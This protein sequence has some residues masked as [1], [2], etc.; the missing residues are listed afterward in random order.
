MAGDRRALVSVGL[1]VLLVSS[2]C[3][4][5]EGPVT[6]EANQSTVA[7]EARQDTGYEEVRVEDQTVVRSFGAA[8]VSQEVRVV[9]K[10][11]EYKRQVDLAVLTGELA[12]FSVFTSPS[13]EVAGQQFNPVSD[14]TNAELA[15]L[16]QEEYG[17]VSDVSLEGNRTVELVGRQATVSRFTAR[18]ETVA[19]QSVDVYLHIGQAAHENDYVVVIAVYPRQLDEQ[20][21]V[22]RLIGGVRHQTGS[23]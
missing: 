13:V 5:L 1:A 21:A 6:F 12:R 2:G 4:F 7:E 8:N 17:T 9:N 20:A 3:S 23:G 15:E 18:A 22:D 16:V 14:M 10:L 19:G 11:A